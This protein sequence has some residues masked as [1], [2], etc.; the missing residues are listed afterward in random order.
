MKQ[1]EQ[2]KGNH[3]FSERSKAPLKKPA[4]LIPLK[5]GDF[6]YLNADLNKSC[7]RHRYLVAS[8]DGL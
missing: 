2:R 4:Y 6:V 7:A 3:I 5:I 8:V 1:H